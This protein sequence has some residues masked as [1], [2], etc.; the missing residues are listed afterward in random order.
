MK[1][2]DDE[3]LKRILLSHTEQLTDMR[4]DI[5]VLHRALMNKGLISADEFQKAHDEIHKEA[6]TALASLSGSKPGKPN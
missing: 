4:L 2:P 6:K 1:K 3:K 5:L